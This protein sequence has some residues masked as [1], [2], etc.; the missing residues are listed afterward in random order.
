MIYLIILL[1]FTYG[2]GPFVTEWASSHFQGG[3]PPDLGVE[4]E[5]IFRNRTCFGHTK[6]KAAKFVRKKSSTCFGWWF[7]P[8]E[9]PP[10]FKVASDNFCIFL[11]RFKPSHRSCYVMR[12][13]AWIEATFQE[14][15]SVLW[16][17]IWFL[18]EGI[19]QKEIGSSAPQR[20]FWD[21]ISDW[22]KIQFHDRIQ[23]QTTFHCSQL[24]SLLSPSPCLTISC[25]MAAALANPDGKTWRSVRLV[26]SRNHSSTVSRLRF[27]QEVWS[28]KTN[29][30]FFWEV[31]CIQ[32]DQEFWFPW[33]HDSI[34]V[35]CRIVILSIS[36]NKR[37][38]CF[39]RPWK[40][41]MDE[42]GCWSSLA[43]QCWEEL[44]KEKN[45][46]V[47][48]IIIVTSL[49]WLRFHRFKKSHC[50][51]ITCLHFRLH[52]RNMIYTKSSLPI[53]TFSM[54]HKKFV[55]HFSKARLKSIRRVP[56]PGIFGS[57][58]A[59]RLAADRFGA[60]WGP[61]VQRRWVVGLAPKQRYQDS[62]CLWNQ[63][64]LHIPTSDCEGLSKQGSGG[65]MLKLD[66]FGLAKWKV[67]GVV[68]GVKDWRGPQ[69]LAPTKTTHIRVRVK[70][71]Q[72]PNHFVFARF[73]IFNRSIYG[74]H[75]IKCF[76]TYGNSSHV[77]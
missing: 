3:G 44:P 57:G 8:V 31:S 34:N 17:G 6:S 12:W 27:M 72:H 11:P 22:R 56:G 48:Q 68:W 40:N 49:L 15:P 55:E 54:P 67:D 35:Y 26:L 53:Q 14:C 51:I 30:V 28:C 60:L 59:P 69:T 63:P 52:G 74:L 50:I 38:E 2:H 18:A 61:K 24:T 76:S 10:T 46:W 36:P 66:P 13:L 4:L 23:N 20:F 71:P 39:I 9:Y 25:P 7:F 75:T 62:Y 73:K 32:P 65:E 21:I 45:K 16:R 5:K 29:L 47:V 1:P 42:G 33:W 19:F 77:L 70:F 37:S 58:Y 43:S 41:F 64:Q